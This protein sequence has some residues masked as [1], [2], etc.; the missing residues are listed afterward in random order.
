VVCVHGRG[1]TNVPLSQSERYARAATAAGDSV[2]VVEV[3]GDHFVVI[4]VNSG[5]W[6]TIVAKLPGLL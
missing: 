2:E 6:T 5:A 4:D 3:E 1:D